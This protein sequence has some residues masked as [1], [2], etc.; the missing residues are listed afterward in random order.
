M[1]PCEPAAL[2]LPDTLQPKLRE[3]E[4]NHQCS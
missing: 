4:E 2:Q 1:E 3:W